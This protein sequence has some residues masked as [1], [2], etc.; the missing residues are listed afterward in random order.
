MIN[1]LLVIICIAF[2]SAPI[3][4]LHADAPASGSAAQASGAFSNVPAGSWPF[5]AGVTLQ[6]TGIPF[7][8]PGTVGTY[9]G[10]R[11]VTR[12]EFAVEVVRFLTLFS[13][14]GKLQSDSAISQQFVEAKFREHPLALN[15]FMSL[16]DEFMPL[17]SKVDPTAGSSREYLLKFRLQMRFANL[18]KRQPQQTTDSLFA[19]VPRTDW[20][21]MAKVYLQQAGVVFGSPDPF[22]VNSPMTRLEWATDISE[23]LPGM[24]TKLKPFHS[25]SFLGTG[26]RVQ[27]IEQ[28]LNGNPKA[29]LSLKS[30]VTRFTPELTLLGQ[31]MSTVQ[32]WLATL[33]IPPPFSDV[34]PTH[35][36]YQSVETLRK[37][38]IMIGY[39]DNHFRTN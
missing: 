10:T 15:A 26:D 23:L 38:G 27:T 13:E 16:T 22:S 9:G 6:K 5:Q 18:L 32:E 33:G 36:A 21:Y 24:P 20:V 35:W 12:Y 39:P 7:R 17:I 30:L 34:P 14:H 3:C 28:N 25:A 8:Y 37:A 1:R 19:D 29:I 2:A 11:E 4:V 31:N